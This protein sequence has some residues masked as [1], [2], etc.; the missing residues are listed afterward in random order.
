M[1]G[2]YEMNCGTTRVDFLGQEKLKL[3]HNKANYGTK[4]D[5]LGQEKLIL[6]HIKMNFGTKWGVFLGQ[7][8]SILS[9]NKTN[10]WTWWCDFL[11]QAKLILGHKK[12]NSR[13]KQGHFLGYWNVILV[14]IRRWSCGRFWDDNNISHKMK[15]DLTTGTWQ[16]DIW[17]PI[18]IILF[19]TSDVCDVHHI[20]TEPYSFILWFL[21][22]TF[23]Q[24][25]VF[26]L[27]VCR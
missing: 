21:I 3:G 10:Y 20:F 11:G 16:D 5:I 12:M 24:Y 4:Q 18:N 14:H 9:H 13:T 1:L 23:T 25:K 26:I 19:C 27:Y 22:P 2:H 15:N 17:C 7:E 8:K 6:G